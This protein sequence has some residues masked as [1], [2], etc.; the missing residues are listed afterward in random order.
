MNNFRQFELRL[1]I[2]RWNAFSR[3]FGRNFGKSTFS[4]TNLNLIVFTKICES[5]YWNWIFISMKLHNISWNQ[6]FGKKLISRNFSVRLQF[7]ELYATLQS[8]E[9]NSVNKFEYQQNTIMMVLLEL[10]SIF[11]GK[12]GIAAPTFILLK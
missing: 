5:F 2:L 6:F 7:L 3:F 10:C 4:K 8:H 1:A 11:F 9:P 12:K